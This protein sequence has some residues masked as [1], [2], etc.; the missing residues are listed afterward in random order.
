[1]SAS[2]TAHPRLPVGER[3]FGMQPAL[4]LALCLK[5]RVEEQ[6]GLGIEGPVHLLQLQLYGVQLQFGRGLQRGVAPVHARVLQ[7]QQ[8]Q[9]HLPGRSGRRRSGRTGRRGGRRR[10]R[11]L[12]GTGQALQLQLPGRIAAQVQHRTV[13]LHGIEQHAT[14][15]RTHLG[16]LH[17]QALP[18]QQRCVARRLEAE[19]AQ[20]DA[21]LQ[22]DA[23]LAALRLLEAQRQVGGQPAADGLHRQ[24]GRQV[25]PHRAQVERVEADLEFGS[26]AR[27]EGCRLAVV[28][29]GRA[30]ELEGQARLD[31]DLQVVGQVGQEGQVQ[32][33]LAQHMGAAHRTVVEAEFAVGHA[34]VEQ[35]KARRLGR[36]VA[37]LGCEALQQVVD[38]VAAIAQAGQAQ[39]R[40]IELQAGDHRRPAQQRACIDV[41]EQAPDLQLRRGSGAPGAAPS[42]SSRSVSDSVVGANCTS[43][44]RSS[45][46]S[47]CEPRVSS[48]HFSSGGTA[49]QAT[50][51]SSSTASTAQINSRSARDFSTS[52]P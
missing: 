16:Q 41:D 46:P 21:A 19:V 6:L 36:R 42:D 8:R 48:C 30:V 38:V 33:Q 12:G 18:G 29:E 27:G 20:I 1:M 51:Q 22:L 45:R 17:A 37:G 24:R 28:F 49:S 25:G 31:L 44:T 5:L 34:Q 3:A 10:L 9:L 13:H 14:L 39:S 23:R 26:A 43:P 32:A 35:R 7:L 40:R 4:R 47:S 50:A 52:F 11:G 2:C 15:Q